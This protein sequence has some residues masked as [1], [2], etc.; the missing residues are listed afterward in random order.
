MI[1]PFKNNLSANKTIHSGEFKTAKELGSMAVAQR[2][3]EKCEIVKT[4]P[5]AETKQMLRLLP[6]LMQLMKHGPRLTILKF[7]N[8]DSVN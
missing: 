5:L 2:T 3:Q 6:Q 4:D 1:N 8:Q 7:L